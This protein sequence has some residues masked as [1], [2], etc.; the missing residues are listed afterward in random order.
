MEA[1][2]FYILYRTLSASV[3][4][5]AIFVL[6][7]LAAGRLSPTVRHGLWL[8]LVPVMLISVTVIPIPVTTTE[9]PPGI[10]TNLTAVTKID[11]EIPPMPL[12]EVFAET[13]VVSVAA[14]NEPPQRS[15]LISLPILA[16]ALWLFGIAALTGLSAF[17]TLRYRRRFFKSQEIMDENTLALLKRCRS[18]M[19][20]K[21]PVRLLES[22]RLLA[23]VLA[24]VWRPRIILPAGFAEQSSEEQLAHLFL[25]EI[26][27]LK[28]RDIVT[29]WMMSLLCIVHWFNPLV[30]AA[31]RTMNADGEEAADQSAMRTFDKQRRIEY[32]RTLLSLTERLHGVPKRLLHVPGFVGLMESPFQLSRRIEMLKQH[33]SW[34]RGWT[35]LAIVLCFVVSVTVLTRFEFVAAQETLKEPGASAPGLPEPPRT[36]TGESPIRGLT[37]PA[38]EQSKIAPNPAKEG[39]FEPVRPVQD[40]KMVN[41]RARVLTPN[42]EVADGINCQFVGYPNGWT[43]STGG[44]REV[45]GELNADVPSNASYVVAV[46]DKRNRYA[47]PMQTITVGDE[48]PEGELVFQFE[49]GVPLTATFV[50]EE[51]G[52]PIPGL[53]I[54]LMQK[55]N[56]PKGEPRIFFEKTSDEKGLFQAHVMPGEYVLS[57]DPLFTNPT[58]IQKGVHARKFVAKE[59]EPVSLE[60]RIPGLFVGKVLNVD[61]TPAKN[62]IVFVLPDQREMGADHQTST[63]TSTDQD[64]L[65]R[66]ILKPVNVSVNV[67]AMG[68]AG[69]YFAWFGEELAETKEYTFQLVAGVEVKGR[70]LNAQTNE[71][72]DGQLFWCWKANANDP[73]QKQFMP[74]S[75]QTNGSGRFNIRL[76]PTVLNE[77]FVVYGRQS[78]HGGGPYE[79]R[80]DMT[81]LGPE[82]LKGK[83]V[84]DLGD[85]LLDSGRAT[86][87]E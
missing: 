45:S 36:P 59:G 27:H 41:V 1:A 13:P 38:P 39:T 85:L 50:D 47:A 16:A 53:R 57:V 15:R 20:V 63:F 26:A 23:P 76:N 46:F 49:K 33:E 40:E 5:V 31:L 65:F 29:G 35:F 52:A 34:H 68:G 71:P 25:H 83:D 79:P 14:K 86:K 61:G 9:A 3:V 70:L 22:N 21:K 18:D 6:R 60:F 43:I 81:T 10:G 56:V 82:Q 87:N 51:T 12:L 77:L 32:G 17:Q 84:I 28:R 75:H 4:I 48:P 62:R 58:A 69:Q 74:D 66:R 73:K 42:G 80:I 19:N 24:G 67:L 11:V 8:F 2:F 78:A 37:P 30:W 64:G 7:R 54:F 72:L 55:A 44:G